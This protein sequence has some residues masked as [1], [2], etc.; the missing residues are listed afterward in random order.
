METQQIDYTY[1]MFDNLIGRKVTPCDSGGS[2][3]APS[4][5][6]YVFDGTNMVLAFD[7]N[8]N[9]TD[10][11]LW[12]AAVD[13]V[14]ADE[15]FT[16]TIGQTNQ[17]PGAGTA[18]DTFWALGNNQNSVRDMVNDSGALVQHIAYSPFGQQTAQS[19]GAAVSAF[20]YTGTYTD[21]VTKLQLHGV[22]WY[23]PASQRWLS[24]DPSG[25]GGGDSNLYRYVGNSAP[26]SVDPSGLYAGGALSGLASCWGQ[27]ANW[28]V[29]NVYGGQESAI[30][31]GNSVIENEPLAAQRLRAIGDPLSSTVAAALDLAVAD[32]V[33]A[34]AP[35]VAARRP[36]S[37]C[38]GR[39]C[40]GAPAPQA[41]ALPGGGGAQGAAQPGGAQPGNVDW[42]KWGALASS[43]LALLGTVDFGGEAPK[44]PGGDA[45]EVPGGD[46]PEVPGDEAPGAERPT[47]DTSLPDRVTQELPP[48][49]I[50]TPEET[51]Q[52]RNFFEAQPSRGYGLV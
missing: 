24:Q 8:R 6:R 52:A 45:P 42:R 41:A 35:Q 1:D 18:L 19:S 9:L 47:P 5:Q 50:R 20:G 3:L 33:P 28:V 27:W 23:D 26:N 15:H 7:G 43:L 4:T 51:A 22:R 25:F 11:Y 39:R 46:A 10:R 21:P 17:L 29:N 30:A 32:D 2:K 48:G 49:E 34:P 44:V 31:F 12:G 40:G 13:Q 38:Q 37:A 16:P 36:G 14:L